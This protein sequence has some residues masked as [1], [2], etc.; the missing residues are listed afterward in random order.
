M[1]AIATDMSLRDGW[2]Y[3]AGGADPLPTRHLVNYQRQQLGLA[4][5]A[6]GVV[7]DVAD[8]GVVRGLLAGAGVGA[9]GVVVVQ[10]SVSEVSHAFNVVRDV[11]GVT[12]LD[13]QAGRLAVA[14]G[15][16][17]AVKFLPMTVGLV[18]PAG[19]RVSDGSELVGLTGADPDRQ[20]VFRVAEGVSEPAPGTSD[21]GRQ[22]ASYFDPSV[23]AGP[24]T[25]IASTTPTEA[26]QPSADES[27]AGPTTLSPTVP[28]APAGQGR[29]AGGAPAHSAPVHNG[30]G[31]HASPPPSAAPANPTGHAHIPESRGSRDDPTRDS[32]S[33]GDTGTAMQLRA[34]AETVPQVRDRLRRWLAG[35]RDERVLSTLPREDPS[36]YPGRFGRETIVERLAQWSDEVGKAADEDLAGLHRD[37]RDLALQ[38]HGWRQLFARVGR[39]PTAGAAT[40]ARRD[41]R[42]ER[43]VQRAYGLQFRVNRIDELAAWRRPVEATDEQWTMDAARDALSARVAWL[44]AELM[45]AEGQHPAMGVDAARQPEVEDAA[46]RLTDLIEDIERQVTRMTPMWQEPEHDGDWRPAERYTPGPH[47]TPSD[48]SRPALGTES[49]RAVSSEFRR[50]LREAA[51][52]VLPEAVRDAADAAAAID[53]ALSEDLLVVAGTEFVSDG[54]LVEIG[55]YAVRLG[56][57]LGGWRQVSDPI[58]FRP[59]VTANRRDRNGRDIGHMKFVDVNGNATWVFDHEVPH[60]RIA[61]VQDASYLGLLTLVLHEHDQNRT[62]FDAHAAEHTIKGSSYR[63]IEYLFAAQPWVEVTMPDGRRSATDD[64]GSR[65]LDYVP[66]GVRLLVSREATIPDTPHPASD[67]MR[68]KELKASQLPPAVVWADPGAHYRPV[69]PAG[70]EIRLPFTSFVEVLPGAWQIRR[71]VEDYL[72]DDVR[73]GT[74]SYRQVASALRP[75]VLRTRLREGTDGHGYT[76]ELGQIVGQ[77]STS[78]QVHFQLSN[79]QPVVVMDPYTWADA[80][81][82]YRAG[83]SVDEAAEDSIDVPPGP[84]LTAFNLVFKWGHIEPY[85]FFW[86]TVDAVVV[87][88]GPSVD[89]TESSGVRLTGEP[90]AV[91]RFD[92]K[93]R[94]SR[95]DRPGTF[96][97]WQAIRGGVQVRV[98]RDDARKWLT[99]PDLT[100]DEQAR[101]RRP[102]LRMP[103]RPFLPP[104][105]QVA[106]VELSTDPGVD[107]VS[108]TL[109]L[110]RE[111]FPGTVPFADGRA[112]RF[113]GA[114]VRELADSRLAAENLAAVRERLRLSNFPAIASRAAT[115][116]GYSFRL[117]RKD[118]TARAGDEV[119]VRIRAVLPSQNDWRPTYRR[120]LPMAEMDAFFS[121]NTDLT[122]V[123]QTVTGLWAGVEPVAAAT[124]P[125]PSGH[126]GGD[127]GGSSATPPDSAAKEAVRRL[128]LQAVETRPIV[129]GRVVSTRSQVSGFETS[130]VHGLSVDDAAEFALG[131]TFFIQVEGHR[132]LVAAG[133]E[134]LVGP[135]MPGS[136]LYE[137]D[138][139][140]LESGV[141]SEV[142]R[143][144]NAAGPALRKVVKAPPIDGMYTVLV[145]SDLTEER[146]DWDGG[147]QWV[148]RSVARLVDS[149][150][151]APGATALV[152]GTGQPLTFVPTAAVRLPRT[153]MLMLSPSG[154]IQAALRAF[155]EVGVTQ[156]PA[157]TR[158]ELETVLAAEVNQAHRLLDRAQQ[159]WRGQVGS[160]TDARVRL[161]FVAEQLT[162]VGLAD[163]Y[164]AFNDLCATSI[165]GLGS[166]TLR[167]GL[168]ALRL[169]FPLDLGGTTKAPAGEERIAK[170]TLTPQPQYAHRRERI[171]GHDTESSGTTSRGNQD[172]GLQVLAE[173][174]GH[175]EVSVETVPTYAFVSSRRNSS[176]VTVATVGLAGLSPLAASPLGLLPPQLMTTLDTAVAYE[177]PDFVRD[178]QGLGGSVVEAPDISAFISEI[179]QSVEDRYGST[180]SEALEEELDKLTE[181]YTTAAML[182]MFFS[183]LRQPVGAASFLTA[184]R[185]PVLP[186]R[187]TVTVEMRAQYVRDQFEG[188]TR[189]GQEIMRSDSQE[190]STRDRENVI[191]RHTVDVGRFWYVNFPNRRVNSVWAQN[192]STMYAQTNRETS[193]AT[194]TEKTAGTVATTPDHGGAAV[195][196]IWLALSATVRVDTAPAAMVDAATLGATQTSTVWEVGPRQLADPATVVYD[197]RLLEPLDTP[198]PPDLATDVDDPPTS[199]SAA[200]PGT[201]HHPVGRPPGATRPITSEP[202]TDPP[203][204]TLSDVGAFHEIIRGTRPPVDPRALSDLR[205]DNIADLDRVRKL[206]FRL[207]VPSPLPYTGSRWQRLTALW[208]NYVANPPLGA[209]WLR[210]RAYQEDFLASI[211]NPV[212]LAARLPA[213]LTDGLPVPVRLPGRFFST[214][215]H[216]ELFAEVVAVDRGRSTDN[217]K[218][219]RG[220]ARADEVRNSTAVTAGSTWQPWLNLD[221]PKN[222]GAVAD[223]A[224]RSNAVGGLL[225]LDLITQHQDKAQQ[226]SRTSFG[227]TD[228]STGWS[229]TQVRLH[230]RWSVGL[231]PATSRYLANPPRRA[232][233]ADTVQQITVSIPSDLVPL[234]KNFPPAPASPR[235]LPYTHV[236]TGTTQLNADPN[237]I[238]TVPPTRPGHRPPAATH[239]PAGQPPASDATLPDPSPPSPAPSRAAAA[240]QP[241]MAAPNSGD[242]VAQRGGDPD[243]PVSRTSGD[244]IGQRE[245]DSASYADTGAPTGQETAAHTGQ[246]DGAR[247][248]QETGASTAGD[249]TSAA[250]DGP[251]TRNAGQLIAERAGV[252][253]ER[254][255]DVAGTTDGARTT[256]PATTDRARDNDGGRSAEEHRSG[257][258]PQH[259]DDL[260]REDEGGAGPDLTD[261]GVYLVDFSEGEKT[262]RTSDEPKLQDLA[263]NMSVEIVRRWRAGEQGL[264]IR[265]EGGGNG[266]GVARLMRPRRAGRQAGLRRAE[267]VV[268]I[269][270][271]KLQYHLSQRFGGQSGLNI[272]KILDEILAE[273]QSRGNGRSLAPKAPY[274]DG[275]EARRRAAVWR[276]DDG[277]LRPIG[278]RDE[279]GMQLHVED[280]DALRAYIDH[281]VRSG[282]H[283]R[284]KVLLH[285]LS[286]LGVS[287]LRTTLSAY[288]EQLRW[289]IGSL[290]GTSSERQSSEAATPPTTD[291]VSVGAPVV[292]QG[293]RHDA[294]HALAA[295]QGAEAIDRPASL[296]SPAVSSGLGRL[297][298][299]AVAASGVAGDALRLLED[300]E[301]AGGELGLW[302]GYRDATGRQDGLRRGIADAQQRLRNVVPDGWLRQGPEPAA[303]GP[304]REAEVEGA[305]GAVDA[306]VAEALTWADDVLRRWAKTITDLAGAVPQRLLRYT[307][308][309]GYRGA[310]EAGLVA[311][312]DGGVRHASTLLGRSPRE[313]TPDGV[314]LMRDDVHRMASVD[315]SGAM[316]E[317]WPAIGEAVADLVGRVREVPGQVGQVRE[318]LGGLGVEQA[319]RIGA[320][321][322][323]VE[324]AFQHEPAT[325]WDQ[326]GQLW[327]AG[328]VGPVEMA[329][330]GRALYYLSRLEAARQATNHALT[331][332]QPSAPPREGDGAQTLP[333][334]RRA[335][336]PIPSAHLDQ[337]RTTTNPALDEARPTA[338]GGAQPTASVLPDQE[339]A[340]TPPQPPTPTPPL[341]RGR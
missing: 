319:G 301:A 75:E 252:G 77:A 266:S 206:A 167:G 110:L 322:N 176:T 4:D 58:A 321:L 124:M 304:V 142:G 212:F 217:V 61:L 269:L 97:D 111:H 323:E 161:R 108:I 203:I 172:I 291:R 12:F 43:L 339:P 189:N 146:V 91:L 317:A 297:W 34:R 243:D 134:D 53:E 244:P 180:I 234:L 143:D 221:W 251:A 59:K 179:V 202:P 328:T 290:P 185:L 332:P 104:I 247:A 272:D 340:R 9:R 274:P 121:H 67:T 24:T 160:F 315:V 265:V 257:G 95:S 283:N 293:A 135:Y 37:I 191:R 145:P 127:H 255:T 208:D 311:A 258:P 28:N 163:S 35:M 100:I 92:L 278:L 153:T 29:T 144:S 239:E 151:L 81:R 312:L 69:Q 205:V 210:S 227:R 336:E 224:G 13:G 186:G 270:R 71:A 52:A 230:V 5:D 149:G 216:L 289:S 229:Y 150:G 83:F 267:A 198:A 182:E 56:A 16:V 138:G 72:G 285:E 299:A 220:N 33:A 165:A 168:F 256:D 226:R 7:F 158:I 175:F 51:L 177:L 49:V 38:V 204:R 298:S 27:S 86:P 89:V 295:E 162:T 324:Q 107:L 10:S 214:D 105:L 101:D 335:P 264:R 260:Q 253:A 102:E 254:T 307:E 84:L 14:P 88:P 11:R 90:T 36:A 46:A 31:A 313:V 50:V 320:T 148:P 133:L 136:Y 21:A 139:V 326:V 197:P 268:K 41:E 44:V 6:P 60:R 233:I 171:T 194:L 54:V 80:S 65:P 246:D 318:L 331:A 126:H 156:L 48:G 193:L 32:T 286:A 245:A 93:I 106:D 174:R 249:R 231:R 68:L 23:P 94:L 123:A 128:L 87:R 228:K 55:G 238:P 62:T 284:V 334:A 337:A 113:S 74:L 223:N 109:N 215:A 338:V 85:F 115:A 17:V 288:Y 276:S 120:W 73:P 57:V 98:L 303:A 300:V 119:V 141:P 3:Q 164:A 273:P 333:A 20:P 45:A 201:L 281:A 263:R 118:L 130:G 305:V 114:V 1:T 308:T 125:K 232:I 40:P 99:L 155:E 261:D 112:T 181:P 219:R 140:D 70:T 22:A 178:S 309:L 190:E 117:V 211:I 207:V 200:R 209:S 154:L 132:P 129:R 225:G 282:E 235:P 250:V 262:V 325:A 131:V 76:V 47:L 275:A 259:F 187:R 242:P 213:L 173:V 8:F 78:V 184:W 195:F 294:N 64:A 192:N 327:A 103:Y 30:T 240:V 170:H 279:H 296:L 137:Q 241:A 330:V 280:H 166:E 159:V 341:P 314:A 183:T 237:T 26:G 196:K 25:P 39:Q 277:P 66:D 222:G 292:E 63:S 248:G 316:R 2:G 42:F 236:G 188:V 271:D 82:T 19:V 157:A 96:S 79:P 199:A 116:D 152:G 169:R 218:V 18:A 287:G 147:R 15:S 329:Q 122:R 310:N 306:A 302:A